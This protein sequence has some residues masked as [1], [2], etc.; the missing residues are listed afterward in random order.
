MTDNK[1]T[2]TYALKVLADEFIPS[3]ISYIVRSLANSP[4][5]KEYF[6]LNTSMTAITI[7]R[8]L[9]KLHKLGLAYICDWRFD[10]EQ[11]KYIAFW[12]L[13]NAPHVKR[14]KTRR[15]ATPPRRLSTPPQKPISR[16]S[17]IE[18]LRANL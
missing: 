13:G 18:L 2:D 6:V 17:F 12:T 11:Q 10:V 5:S 9:T 8:T 14:H 4:K 1:I 15:T 7:E 3:Y 16:S